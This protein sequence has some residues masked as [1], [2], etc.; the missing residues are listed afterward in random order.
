MFLFP[1]PAQGLG[2]GE[3]LVV[4]AGFLAEQSPDSWLAAVLIVI[5]SSF[6]CISS[7]KG[8]ACWRRCPVRV[9]Q[10]DLNGAA[11]R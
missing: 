4:V 10:V 7:R 8:Q 11:L 5:G 1:A 3:N 6:D 9:V 2:E